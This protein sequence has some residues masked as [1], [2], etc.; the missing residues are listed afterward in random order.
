MNL[1][2]HIRCT[3]RWGPNGCNRLEATGCFCLN[4]IYTFANKFLWGILF[5][6][7]LKFLLTLVFYVRNDLSILVGYRKPATKVALLRLI[8]NNTKRMFSNPVVWRKTDE[9]DGIHVIYINGPVVCFNSMAMNREIERIPASA[10][11]VQ[12]FFGPGVALIDH[13]SV[14]NLIAFSTTMKLRRNVEVELLGFDLMCRCSKDEACMRVAN[15]LIQSRVA[16]TAA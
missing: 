7:A 2:I 13:T 14:T 12:F 16:Y 10:Q 3:K 4:Y 11:K 15:P 9:K 8:A 1:G 5:G 6:T